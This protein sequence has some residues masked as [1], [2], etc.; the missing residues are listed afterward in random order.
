MNPYHP[1]PKSAKACANAYEIAPERA[2][3]GFFRKGWRFDEDAWLKRRAAAGK[4]VNAG[5]RLPRISKT[6]A[7]K[8]KGNR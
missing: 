1:G 6:K 3:K 2:L 5:A 7:E 4:P 8:T